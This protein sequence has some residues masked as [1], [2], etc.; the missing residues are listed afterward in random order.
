MKHKKAPNKEGFL[1]TRLHG[2]ASASRLTLSK[3]FVATLTNQFVLYLICSKSYN[4]T[5]LVS[6]KHCELSLDLWQTFK[7]KTNHDVKRQELPTHPLSAWTDI[8]LTGD[9]WNGQVQTSGLWLC[10]ESGEDVRRIN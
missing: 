10:L 7:I 8:T 2:S 5:A 3:Q 6:P 9:E 1:N 4:K